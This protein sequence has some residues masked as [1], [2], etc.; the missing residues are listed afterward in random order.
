MA[1]ENGKTIR[2]LLNAAPLSDGDFIQAFQPDVY[3]TI[4]HQNGDTRK[5]TVA[6][7]GDYFTR[8]AQKAAVGEYHFLAFQPND[9]W[10]AKMRYLPLLGQIIKIADY[11]D[12][13]TLKWCG[14]S[15]NATAYFWYK[16]DVDGAR[17]ANG[18]Y[19]H[20]EDGRGMFYRGAGAN[21]V[22]KG[23]NNTPYDGNAIGAFLG[24]ASRAMTGN[25]LFAAYN[26]I[27]SILRLQATGV[28]RA[29]NNT[30]HPVLLPQELESIVGTETANSLG[31]DISNTVPVANEF[32]CASLSCLS[33]ISY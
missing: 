9:T 25:A 24:D 8:T 28:F 2:E 11:Q 32:R 15:K 10:L 13:C 6:E 26:S 12:L 14:S 30:E 17:N 19:M 20:V 1:L 4:M 7:L 5:I 18:L 27:W 21:S 16:C 3:N 33:C 22:F 29:S 23:A 31:F